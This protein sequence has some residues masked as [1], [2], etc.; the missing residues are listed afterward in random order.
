MKKGLWSSEEDDIL[1]E[2]FKEHVRRG[3]MAP[4]REEL[5]LVSI[6][7]ELPACWLY[8]LK[9]DLKKGPITTEEEQLFIKLHRWAQIAKHSGDLKN[10]Q[11]NA[12][13]FTTDLDRKECA[14][15]AEDATN[16]PDEIIEDDNFTNLVDEPRQQSVAVVVHEMEKQPPTD[17]S[18][19]V[20][21]PLMV[22]LIITYIQ[23]RCK[24]GNLNL[25]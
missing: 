21:L 9:P 14:S 24:E 15:L 4:H 1:S 18:K 20:I 12:S 6:V 25:L 19:S 16:F 8:H 23:T 17:D 13:N 3:E 7:E 11:E 5:G 2:Y 22:Y 10:Q